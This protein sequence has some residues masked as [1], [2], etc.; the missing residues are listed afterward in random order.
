MLWWTLRQLKSSNAQKRA[1]TAARLGTSGEKGA[2]PALIEAL[3]DENAEVRVAVIQALRVL[4]DAAAAEPL[5]RSLEKIAARPGQKTAGAERGEYEALAGALGSLGPDAVNPLIRLLD[6]GDRETRRWAVYG[7]GLTHDARA[8]DSLIKHLSDPR[9]EVRKAAALALGTLGGAKALAALVRAV[10]N[11]D[12]ET[13][14]AAVLSLGALGG[15]A[16]LES[17]TVVAEDPNEPVQLAV[18]EALLRIGGLRAGSCI[19]SLVDGGRKNV[20]EAA[21]AALQSLKIAPANAEERAL[22]AVLV[23]DFDAAVKEGE[24]AVGPLGGV[25]GSKDVSR[26]R[27]AAGALAQL[28][29]AAA[30]RPAFARISGF[31][32]SRPQYRRRRAGRPRLR[33]HRRAHRHAF[34]S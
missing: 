2:L 28:R 7:L 20:R 26:R 33:L 8:A 15:D 30:V 34:P 29:A 16:A 24:S 1:E 13:R 4:H 31:R 23:G 19:R 27:Q 5:A 12:Q 3:D 17:L 11:R 10:S 9:S 25:L 18:V 14:H 32:F 21:L 22:A 6:S